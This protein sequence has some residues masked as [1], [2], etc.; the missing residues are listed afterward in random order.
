MAKKRKKK[1]I[2]LKKLRKIGKTKI[3]PVAFFSIIF[4]FS[5]LLV[6]FSPAL[7]ASVSAQPAPVRIDPAFSYTAILDYEPPQRIVIPKISL[8]LPIAPAKIIDGYWET[9]TTSASFGLGSAYPNQ[10]VGNT[11]IFAH[12]TDNYFGKLRFLSPPDLIYLFTKNDWFVYEILSSKTV[13]PSEVDVVSP[14]K[15][16]T[17]TLYTCDGYN[18]IYRLVVVAK[19][20]FS[21]TVVTN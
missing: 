4:F 6:I 2:F 20:H 19:P 12:A 10:T 11:V 7:I 13:L 14:T 5:G 18:D 1:L 21:R 15:D 16:K 8:D 3:R 9:S 17:L